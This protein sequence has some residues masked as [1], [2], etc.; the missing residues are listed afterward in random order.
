M[1]QPPPD[2]LYRLAA[3]RQDHVLAGWDSL[4]AAD[5]AA[6]VEQLAGVDLAELEALHRRKD[7]PHAVLPPRDRVAPIPVQPTAA[8][9]EARAAGEAALRRGEVAALV[10][11]GGQGVRLGFDHPKGLYPV[12]PVSQAPLFQVH[13]EKVLALTRRYDKP[14]PLLV[15]TSPATHAETE[16]FFRDRRYF[17]LAPADV[18]F[19]RQGTMPAL[20]LATGKLL[21]EAPGRLFLAPNGHGGTLTALRETGL[22]DDLDARGVRHVFYFQVDNPLVK[23]CDPG[24]VGRHVAAGSEASSKVVFKEQPGERVGVLA[25]VDGRCGIIEYSDLPP[26]MA[27]EREADGALRFRAGS[28]AIHLFS[29]PFLRRVTG[30]GGLPFHVA[31]KKAPYYDPAAGRAVTPDAE[32]ALKFERFV[33]D[34]LPLADRWV[35]VETRREEEFAP[36]KNTSGADSPETVRRAWV[37]LHADWLEAAGAVVPRD[38]AGDPVHPVEVSPL[39]ALE[40]DDLRGK[41][42]PGYTVTKPSYLS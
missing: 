2:L 17:G 22:L 1:P 8:P 20:D 16:A 41:L 36:L 27:A 23:V 9:P 38:A 30:Q 7:E 25:L 35:V 21:L 37:R 13:A 33:F 14:V 5:R 32:N 40:A 26:D 3:H 39:V 19:F 28:P 18:V 42:P 34:A 29:L 12:G 31:R 10:V 11:A 4:S 24:F 15:M 6:L